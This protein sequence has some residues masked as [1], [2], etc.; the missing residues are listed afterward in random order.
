[1][2]RWDLLAYNTM[3]TVDSQ[4]TFNWSTSPPS[5]G[6]KNRISN[7]PARK[8]AASTGLPVIC[9][10]HIM[11]HYTPEDITLHKIHFENL[12]SYKSIDVQDIHF[13]TFQTVVNFLVSVVVLCG[14][15]CIKNESSSS[16]IHGS[17]HPLP[18][19]FMA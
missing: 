7:K 14:H 10:Q 19:V 2:K 4:L 3:Q 8:Q 16:R 9:F 6:L 12:K 5:S 13:S 15:K 1:M 17:I 11:W 18:H